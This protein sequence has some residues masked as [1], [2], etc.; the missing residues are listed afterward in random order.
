M[1][2]TPILKALIVV[3]LT[4]IGIQAYAD[5][6]AMPMPADA[7]LVE[8]NFEPNDTFVVLTRPKSVTD[9]VL[10]PDEEIVAL[11]LGDTFQ[12]QTK[13]TKG[14]VFVKPV[15]PNITTSVTLVTTARTYQ[16]TL[17]ASP[18]DGKWYQRVSFSYPQLMVIER[19]RA[20]GA[21][22][23]VEAEKS[24]LDAQV[25]SS[26]VAVDKL[27]W[28]YSVKGKA[29]FAPTQVF[30]DGKFTWL[31]M[32]KS[33]DMP[34]F[35]LVAPNGDYELL[36]THLKGDYVVIQRTLDKVALKLGEE[37]VIVQ[38]NSGGIFSG[39]LGR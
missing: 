16:F 18:E 38:R 15:R 3:A 23:I 26:G 11:A 19:E 5:I 36:N 4:S 1:K 35:F 6:K 24:R 27:N 22:R 30:D 10:H 8:F 34:A 25:A 9:I 37:E 39:F 20:E 32:P 7:K 2:S 28:E 12:W 17:Q 14:H 21:R 31:R 33:Q 29:K 13:D